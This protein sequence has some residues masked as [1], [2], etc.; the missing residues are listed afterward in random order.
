MK[1][2]VALFDFDGTLTRGDSLVPFLK[3]V[4]GPAG[5]AGAMAASLPWLAGY[6]LRLT[7]NDVAKERLLSSALRGRR[8]AD[9]EAAGREFARKTVPDMLRSDMMAIV[10]R[11]RAE[12][13][14]CV[15]VSA[16]LDLYLA[17][18][19]AEAGFDHL[20]C[21]RLE[22]DERQC[23]T[24]RLLDG[25]CHGPRKVALIRKLF[26]DWDKAP[27]DIV[28]YGDTKGD[29]PMLALADRAFLVG[30]DGPRPFNAK[31]ALA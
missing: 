19:A 31:A 11:N 15:L 1:D 10:E 23:V 18:W 21:S 8:H 17:P 22:T 20:L 4:A 3:A 28:A 6:A 26:A 25:N 27:R 5:L 12:G 2:S 16:S 30:K 7:R 9:L 24:G 13:R 29:F 14:R